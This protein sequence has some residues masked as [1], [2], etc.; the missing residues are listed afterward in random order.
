[1]GDKSL[2]LGTLPS[3]LTGHTAGMLLLL[4]LGLQPRGGN[5]TLG[6]VTGKV[7]A[8]HAYGMGNSRVLHL[9]FLHLMFQMMPAHIFLPTVILLPD[10]VWASW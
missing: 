9:G 1:M 5:L 6:S 7:T 8:P 2:D 3:A 10:S 4:N